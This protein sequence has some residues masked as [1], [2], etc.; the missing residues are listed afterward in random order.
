MMH[1]LILHL[2]DT[3]WMAPPP[4]Y[5]QEF[6]QEDQFTLVGQREDEP[7]VKVRMLVDPYPPEP[8]DQDKPATD[9]PADKIK[10]PPDHL[11]LCR[12]QGRR[13]KQAAI[14]SRVETK[15]LDL[16]GKL[17]VRVETGRIKDPDKIHRLIGR[18]QQRHSRVQRCYTVQLKTD[19]TSASKQRLEWQRIAED[20]QGDDPLLGGYVLRLDQDGGSPQEWWKLYTTLAKAEAGF[21]ALK[22]DLGLRPNYH[23]KEI[24]VAGHVFITVLA[25]HLMW[26]ILQTLQAAGDHRSWETIRCLLQTQAY[27]TILRPTREGKLYRVRRAGQPEE[28]QK[29]IYEIL[30]VGW[31]SLPQFTTIMEKSSA[32]TL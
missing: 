11:V 15:F 8:E 3:I 9:K 18:L 4:K 10:D 25:Y 24:R 30:K 5:S 12:R 17:A 26:S 27:T 7:P 13:Q 22:S 2:P 21:R 14:R 1:L 6:A 23:Q 19:E 16:L 31:R 20:Y 29:A 28:C 32:T